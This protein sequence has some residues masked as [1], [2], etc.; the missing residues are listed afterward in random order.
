VFVW[1]GFKKYLHRFVRLHNVGKL[2]QQQIRYNGK[3]F[4]NERG[5]CNEGWLHMYNIVDQQIYKDT[6]DNVSISKNPPFWRREGDTLHLSLP[7]GG[8]GLPL[9]LCTVLVLLPIFL[10]RLKKWG[11][12][13][14]WGGLPG[15][16]S[17]YGPVLHWTP[18]LSCYWPL[19]WYC[20]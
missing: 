6:K 3:I 2:L 19:C 4:G 13:G 20:D 18:R 12:G 10:H 15:P 7:G 16:S 14:G 11:W 17:S 9:H 5:R 8:S 1:D